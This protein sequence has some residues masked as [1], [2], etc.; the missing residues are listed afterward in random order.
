MI[1]WTKY[2]TVKRFKEPE[3]WADIR[4]PNVS[5]FERPTH[6]DIRLEIIREVKLMSNW[7]YKENNFEIEGCLLPRSSARQPQLLQLTTSKGRNHVLCLVIL[8]TR[9]A[10]PAHLSSSAALYKQ[11]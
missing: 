3:L 10:L 4:M 6:D 9:N 1:L 8:H 11:L 7:L 5:K 2:I